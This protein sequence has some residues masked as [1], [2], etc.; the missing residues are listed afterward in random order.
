MPSSQPEPALEGRSGHRF[1]TTHWSVVL[2][3]GQSASS[4]SAEALEKLCRTYWS[5]LYAY[6][7]HRG[8]DAHEAQDLTQEFFA[9]LLQKRY[10]NRVDRTKGKFRC[11]LLAALK[12]FLANE[13]DKAKAQKRGGKQTFISLDDE[14]AEKQYVFGLVSDLSPERIYEQRWAQ[15]LLD[16]ALARLWEEFAAQGKAEQFDVLKVF[17]QEETSY[18]DYP[19]IA[20]Q[21][22]MNPSALAMA[23][24]RLRHRYRGLLVSEI[25]Q[26][27]ENPAD[28]EEEMR[29][30][31][32]AISSS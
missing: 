23:V 8:H 2:A 28:I 6:V 31:F 18:G 25:A 15:T 10:L 26:T 30:L 13:W 12:H 20:S 27:V 4:D 17:L 14:S 9:R 3:A 19:A 29:H 7:R 1:A 16:Q 22:H 32:E 5:P 21:L 11:F 24:C